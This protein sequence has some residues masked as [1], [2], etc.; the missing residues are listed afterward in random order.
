MIFRMIL[1]SGQIFLPFCHKSRVWQTDRGADGQTDGQ[2][3]FSSLDRVC[4]PFSAVKTK[5]SAKDEIA[6]INRSREAREQVKMRCFVGAGRNTWRRCQAPCKL[7]W[8]RSS[9]WRAA[10]R[11]YTSLSSP[12]P[13]ISNNTAASMPRRTRITN[14]DVLVVFAYGTSKLSFLVYSDNGRITALPHESLLLVGDFGKTAKDKTQ[15]KQWWT[16]MTCSQ[17]CTT[18]CTHKRPLLVIS[19]CSLKSKIFVFGL[20]KCFTSVNVNL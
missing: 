16:K 9:E 7:S 18:H 12:P 1:K 2:T 13:S 4:I 3:E 14:N 15:T 10:S 17:L 20:D 19:L 5:T 6:C 11:Q 8:Q